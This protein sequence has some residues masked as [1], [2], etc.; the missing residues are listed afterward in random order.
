MFGQLKAYYKGIIAA[1]GSILIVLNT[2][3][4]F[5]DFLGSDV[6]HWVVTGIAALTALGVFLKANEVYV[7]KLP[8]GPVLPVPPGAPQVV[9]RD[10]AP[11]GQAP[12]DGT[13]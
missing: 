13:W 6:K 3:G 8:G 7:D 12:P 10:D 9:V 11:G 1:V 4:P 2:I 5:A